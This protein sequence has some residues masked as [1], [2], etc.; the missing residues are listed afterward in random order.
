VTTRDVAAAAERLR[1]ARTP[2]VS[3]GAVTFGSDAPLGF[4]AATMVRDP[5]GHAL[6]VL[7]R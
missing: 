3:P 4:S 5:D 7:A 1:A 6:R 2:F